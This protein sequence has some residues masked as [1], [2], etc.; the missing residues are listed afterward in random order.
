MPGPGGPQPDRRV[1]AKISENG[2]VDAAWH[3]YQRN[4]D[5]AL[6]RPT[7]TDDRIDQVWVSAP[8][9]GALTG[10]QVLDTPAGASDHH[11]LLVTLDTALI[12][13]ADPWAYQ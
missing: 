2:F 10:Y 4:G 1:A 12:D 5:E 3:L 11:G 8:L 6:L 13:T 9:A 7:G